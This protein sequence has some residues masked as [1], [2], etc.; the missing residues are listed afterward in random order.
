M[1][2]FK[3]LGSLKVQREDSRNSSSSSTEGGIAVGYRH[4]RCCSHGRVRTPTQNLRAWAQTIKN[5]LCSQGIWEADCETEGFPSSSRQPSIL[6]SLSPL[7]LIFP[8]DHSFL[9]KQ[10]F[11]RKILL[12]LKRSSVQVYVQILRDHTD[13]H[14]WSP[15]AS[16]PSSH[17]HEKDALCSTALWLGHDSLEHGQQIPTPAGW[18]TADT[19]D[20]ITPNTNSA[21]SISKALPHAKP[22]KVRGE[23]WLLEFSKH[24]GWRPFWRQICTGSNHEHLLQIGSFSVAGSHFQLKLSFGFFF[25]L[26]FLFMLVLFSR[27]LPCVFEAGCSY[28]DAGGRIWPT[29]TTYN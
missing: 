25:F 19:E 29:L 26:I 3:V 18:H 13:L 5:S 28:G 8:N 4:W 2:P 16:K 9:H 27:C 14:K 17:L 1:R 20:L 11:A 6:T 24:R 23:E 7:L 15:L 22:K 21:N 12:H 10:L